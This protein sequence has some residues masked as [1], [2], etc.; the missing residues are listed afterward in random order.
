MPKLRLFSSM[1]NVR[2]LSLL[3]IASFLACGACAPRPQPA[4]ILAPSLLEPCAGPEIETVKTVND[5]AVF[6]IQSEAALQLCD[7]K[8]RA[9]VDLAKSAKTGD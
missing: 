1:R 9:L 3:S 6:G 8:R 7:Q 2:I 5:I 4:L